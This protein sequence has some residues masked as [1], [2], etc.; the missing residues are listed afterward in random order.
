MVQDYVLHM[1][2]LMVQDYVLHMEQAYFSTYSDWRLGG[3]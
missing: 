2:Q 1:L 3:W